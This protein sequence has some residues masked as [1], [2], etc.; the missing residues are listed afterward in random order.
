MTWHHRPIRASA[1]AVLGVAM[2]A[3]MGGFASVAASAS[4]ATPAGYTA[5]AGSVPATTDPQTGPF[6][7][8]SMA[9]EVALQPRDPAGLAS[10]LHGIYTQGSPSYHQWLAAGQFD[11]RYAPAAARAQ[12][13]AS[14]LT[15][16]G[17]KVAASA[18]PF[19][20]RATGSSAQVAAAFHT[21]FSTYRSKKGAAYFQNSAPVSLPS[22]V[23]S[24]V[25]GV[26]GLTNTIRDQSQV[27]RPGAA[28]PAAAGAAA[29]VPPA[30]ESP[31]PTVAQQFAEVN[32][33]TGFPAGY[34]DGPGCSGLTPAQ[35]NSIY[36]APVAI[37][38]TTGK[39]VTIGV[40]E[41]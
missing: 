3:A 12:A 37:G 10:A 17:L 9:I 33:G 23:A 29:P 2:T 7:A 21:K 41:L 30:C 22:S 8:P 18:S 19:L 13:V 24:F 6:T 40:F 5:L 34:G 27:V 31:Y 15:K 20:V 4:P 32:N 16:A 25:Q 35:D 11:A 28:R 26:T 39:G 1:V 14:F 38:R 36:G